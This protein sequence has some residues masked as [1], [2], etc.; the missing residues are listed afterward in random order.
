[1]DITTVYCYNMKEIEREEA[2]MSTIHLSDKLFHCIT[3]PHLPPSSRLELISLDCQFCDTMS[4][5]LVHDSCILRF[6]LSKVRGI[7]VD[8]IDDDDGVVFVVVLSQ[9]LSIKS[10]VKIGAVNEIWLL[11]LLLMLLF[12]LLFMLLLFVWLVP[13]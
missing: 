2:E 12:M 13:N 10:L 8:V 1:M 9:K 7:V 11:L 3:T 6:S 4:Q 5:Q